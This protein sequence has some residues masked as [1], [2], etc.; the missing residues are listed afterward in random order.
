MK[1]IVKLLVFVLMFSVLLCAGCKKNAQQPTV[2]TTAP[3]TEPATVPATQPVEV[4]EPVEETLPEETEPEIWVFPENTTILNVDVG[5]MEVPQA[6]EQINLYLLEYALDAK[7]NDRSFQIASEDVALTIPEE[8]VAN[9]AL[10]LENGGVPEEPVLELD[11]DLLEQVI[12]DRCQVAMLDAMV[13]YNSSK[14]IF[15]VTK[16]RSSVTIDVDKAAE[17][18]SAALQVMAPECTVK[19]DQSMRQPKVF[20]N[21]PRLISGAAE[22]NKY[23]TISLSYIYEPDDVKAKTHTISK[24]EIGAMI[25]F[26]EDYVPYVSGAAVEAFANSMNEKYSVRAQFK[27]TGGGYISVPGSDITQ[28]VDTETLAADVKASLESKTGGTKRANYLPAREVEVVWNGNYVEVDLS[29]QH[30]WV[31]KDGVCVVSTP[32]VSGSVAGDME[33]PNGVYSIRSKSKGTTLVGPGYAT[34]VSYWMPFFQGYGL[35]DATWRSKFGGDEYLYNGSH[36]CVNMPPAAAAQTYDNIEVGTKVVLYGGVTSVKL[37]ERVFS[38]TTSL[39]KQMGEEPFLLDITTED[40]QTLFYECDAPNVLEISTDGMVTLKGV[41]TAKITV[42]A[43]AYGRY[44]AGSVTVTVT[45]T[46]DHQ[47]GWET[48]KEATCAPGLE[49]G[50]CTKCGYTETKEIPPVA[51]HTY[52]EWTTVT[53]PGCQQ[54]G[55]QRSTCGGCGDVKTETIPALNHDFSSGDLCANGCGTAK[56]E[57]P[58]VVEPPVVEP[59]VDE[60]TGEE[61]PVDNTDPSDQGTEPTE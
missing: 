39:N 29:R 55:E 50:T 48:T 10:A 31:Y 53:E 22:A 42:S 51:E 38:G 43:A 58:P 44:K 41:G 45:I 47:V 16:E 54:D 36:G 30:V 61:P 26:N 37:D 24:D 18:L 11:E 4:T 17:A 49:T 35:H 57:E 12:M 1:K 21:D 14:D 23:L 7:V 15:E 52:G 27:T 3:A 46:C 5:G 6:V 28:A 32:I 25:G 2:Q 56:P 60:P 19:V 20:S 34:Y 59:P 9:Y 40:A 33:T 8:S 13:K